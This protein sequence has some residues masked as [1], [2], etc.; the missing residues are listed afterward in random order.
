MT[1]ILKCPFCGGE[2]QVQRQSDG[3]QGYNQEIFVQCIKCGAR[4]KYVLEGYEGS[5][6][7]C[8]EKAIAKW[9]ARA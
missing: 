6:D 3:T 7:E 4:A 8:R 9:N 1:P 5:R 2:G